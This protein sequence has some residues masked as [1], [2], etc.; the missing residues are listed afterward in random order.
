[1]KKT[2]TL[3]ATAALLL[4]TG[5]PANAAKPGNLDKSFSGDGKTQQAFGGGYQR[6]TSRDV[7]VTS[8]G[9]VV[10]V[11]ELRKPGATY[12]GIARMRKDGK[13]DPVFRGNGR[14]T[15]AFEHDDVPHRVVSQGQ[16]RILVGG[17]G[18]GAFALA[19][20]DSD[21][22]P[23]HPFGGAGKVTTDITPGDDV[24]LDLQVLPG[25]KVLAAGLAGDQ[26]A[27]VRYLPTGVPDDTFGGGDGIVLTTDG[28]DGT[29]YDV[30][31]QP[32]GRLL[33]TGST[34]PD[35]GLV[36]VAVSRFDTDG[37]LDETFGGDGRVETFP[38][39][40]E[41]SRG[42]DVKVQ[43]D[44]KVVVGG[45]AFGEGAYS[46]F[47]LARYRANGTP[48]GTFGADG[49]VATLFQPYYA[50]C[51]RSRSSPT[52]RSSRP[53]G[54]RGRRRAGCWP[55]R[56][57]AAAASSTRTSPATAR[58]TSATGATSA[59]RPSGSPCAMVGSSPWARSP[60]STPR[61][62]RASRSRSSS[63]ASEPAAAVVPAG[64]TVDPEEL[65]DR[66]GDVD[67][68]CVRRGDPAPGHV[69]VTAGEEE[70]DRP[71]G[72]MAVVARDRVAGRVRLAEPPAGLAEDNDVAG[73]G[74]EPQ[75]LLAAVVGGE[76]AGGGL[77]DLLHPLDRG[78]ALAGRA[79]P[80]EEVGA[81]VVGDRHL[82]REQRV[83]LQR[84]RSG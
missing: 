17:S 14:R 62:R 55:W 38:S 77:R 39:S 9:K 16:G 35:G 80:V 24:V 82:A 22:S 21:G 64:G 45:Y 66:G 13:P 36:G 84:A 83:G 59:D 78:A 29:A 2:A 26:F 79:G 51:T 19:S 18:G 58:T 20:Y 33:A 46:Y 10:V 57:T 15:T 70:R 48:D 73:L 31:L 30:A 12:W 3:L 27:V 11:S 43:P 65:A 47:L 68:A 4:A 74:A 41:V 32:D 69:G 7:L 52:A 6:V 44:G 42:Y 72:R 61:G 56:A 5:S 37:S 63:N 75:P 49:V 71:G 34:P 50:R 53:A 67:R 28:F 1:M 54:P 76:H 81:A 60:I 25:G 8:T 23:N 40:R